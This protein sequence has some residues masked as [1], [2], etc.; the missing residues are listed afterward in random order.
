MRNLSL[1]LVLILVLVLG[2]A[3]VALAED[4]G[5]G[6]GLTA[7]T[8]T[9]QPVTEAVVVPAVVDPTVAPAPATVPVVATPATTD[10]IAAPT[11]DVVDAPEVTPTDVVVAPVEVVAPKDVPAEAVP[12]EA[13]VV[14]EA[15]QAPE[16][17]EEAAGTADKLIGAVKSGNWQLALGAL[18]MLLVYFLNSVFKI[19]ENL[20]NPSN[21]KWFAVGAGVIVQIAAGLM[22]T[23][24]WDTVILG[25]GASG[26][27]GVG[28]WEV[29]GKALFTKKSA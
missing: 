17:T 2:S 20:A 21:L 23:L 18:L 19:Q 25:G 15:A 29:V 22:G 16:T 28:I 6:P 24:S 27:I 3:S 12:A 10:V 13:E 11:V 7:V 8:A 9:V 1:L 4:V 5:V 14:N 26:L